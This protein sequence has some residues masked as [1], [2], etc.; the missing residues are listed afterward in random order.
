MKQQFFSQK[1]RGEEGFTLVEMLVVLFIIGLILAIAIPNL[2][3]AG[4][5]AKKKADEANRKLISTQADHYYL[6]NGQYPKSVE[7]LVTKKYLRS[8]PTCPTGKGVYVIDTKPETAPDKRVR[9]P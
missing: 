3:A 4:E 9:C 2:Q 6:E 8:V 5:N 1:R 7:E